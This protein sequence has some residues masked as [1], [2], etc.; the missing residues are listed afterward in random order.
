MN[1][2]KIFAIAIFVLAVACCL[3]VASAADNN[4][5]NN[6]TKRVSF[7]NIFSLEL[8]QDTTVNNRTSINDTDL[9]E[10]T[11]T[12]R[13]NSGHLTGRV[14]TCTGSGLV[15]SAQTYVNNLVNKNA[16]QLD[17]HGDWLVMNT[18]NIHGSSAPYNYILTMHDGSYLLTIEGNNLTQLEQFADTYQSS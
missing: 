2:K 18:T 9:T 6:G 10:V 5:A 1:K 13:S 17:N 3:A 14:T 7:D 4:N 15:S 12:I 16:T 8:P 11:Y